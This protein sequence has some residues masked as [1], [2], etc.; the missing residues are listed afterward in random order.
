VRA[1]SAARLTAHGAS[2]LLVHGLHLCKLRPI[3]SCWALLASPLCTH[4]QMLLAIGRSLRCETVAIVLRE[5]IVMAT[6]ARRWMVARCQHA[7]WGSRT[8]RCIHYLHGVCQMAEWFRG[9]PHWVGLQNLRLHQS[10]LGHVLASSHVHLFARRCSVDCCERSAV[11]G[12][13]CCVCPGVSG[14][15]ESDV[16]C[17]TMP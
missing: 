7:P 3:C 4:T 15:A 10:V 5:T 16:C 6:A 13:Q 8:Q 2:C 1:R 17:W 9:C 11:Q 14:L 12:R